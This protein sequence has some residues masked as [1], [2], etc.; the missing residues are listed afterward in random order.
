MDYSLQADQSI[1]TWEP[2]RKVLPLPTGL[3]GRARIGPDWTTLAGNL[4]MKW[5]RTDDSKWRDR[6]KV[7]M[8]NFGSIASRKY[9]LTFSKERHRKIPVRYVYWE[10]CC[11][12]MGPRECANHCNL[13]RLVTH[14]TGIGGAGESSYYLS[15][16]FGKPNQPVVEGVPTELT[17][18]GRR[19]G[20]ADGTGRYNHR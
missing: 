7:G 10:C 4:F 9:L 6:I 8:V 5:E 11:C 14:L 15:M 17:P 19:R 3:V 12:R 13:I 2:L 1:V 16:I 18:L 20:M